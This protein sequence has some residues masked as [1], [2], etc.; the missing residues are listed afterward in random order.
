MPIVKNGL[1]YLK[2][3]KSESENSC[4]FSV[5]VSSKHIPLCQ[6][7]FDTTKIL[8]VEWPYMANIN[9]NFRHFIC[10]HVNNC[11]EERWKINQLISSHCLWKMCFYYSETVSAFDFNGQVKYTILKIQPCNIL[12]S[13]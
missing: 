9:I 1:V 3:L 10:L 8:C 13:H 4:K 5:Q 6:S 11:L 12:K 2:K 7:M